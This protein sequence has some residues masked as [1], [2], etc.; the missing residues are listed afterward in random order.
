[1]FS[2]ERFTQLAEANM[3]LI[4]R[5]AFSYLKDRTEADDVTQNTLLKLY[6]TNRDFKSEEHIRNWLVRVAVNECK[7]SLLSPW[8]RIEP[9]ENCAETLSFTTP[10]HGQLFHSVMELPQ[11]YRI[12]IFMHYYFD[13][14]AKE[15]GSL[16]RLPP[17]TVY[18]HLDR[19]REKLKKC[20]LEADDDA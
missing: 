18:T 2:D 15:I 17:A 14:S 7:K 4:F 12:V 20:L 9:L 19:G 13:Y 3:D 10:E 11:K 1:M 16:L 5:L 6:R 8:R